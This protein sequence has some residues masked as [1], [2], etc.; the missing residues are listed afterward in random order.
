MHSTQLGNVTYSWKEITTS[1]DLLSLGTQL[2][3]CVSDPG[4]CS[5][6]YEDHASQRLEIL[7]LYEGTSLTAMAFL[8]VDLGGLVAMKRRLMTKPP[9]EYSRVVLDL[10]RTLGC[11]VYDVKGDFRHMGLVP[12]NGELGS[13]LD[14]PEGKVFPGNLNLNNV[15]FLHESLPKGLTVEGHLLVCHT[16]LKSLPPGLSV[17]GNVYAQF[18]SEPLEIPKDATIHGSIFC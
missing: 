18:N 14:I 3:I 6:I 15:R 1:Q 12:L 13:V 9:L 17:G 10:L 11:G 2:S 5:S 4:E 16:F 7:A 8:D